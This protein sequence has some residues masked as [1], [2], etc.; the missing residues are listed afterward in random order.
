MSFVFLIVRS[1]YCSEVNLKYDLP[2]VRLVL[3]IRKV[4]NLPAIMIKTIAMACGATH[5]KLKLLGGADDVTF[6]FSLRA[7][8]S[9]AFI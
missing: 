4:P 5:A 8:A 3:L 6:W 2:S 1:V 7:A 9:Y